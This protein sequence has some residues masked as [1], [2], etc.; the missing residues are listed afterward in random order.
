MINNENNENNENPAFLKEQIITYLGNKRAL[1][2]F[3][4][5]GF[6]FARQE[7]K[8]DKFSFCDAFS[9]SG[10]VSRFAKAYSSFIVANDLEDYSKLINSCYLSNKND[11]NIKDLETMHQSLCENLELKKGFISTLYAPKNDEYIQKNERVFYTQRNALYLDSMRSKIEKE[12]PKE[13]QHFFIAPLIYS[14]SVHSNTGGVF[15]GF[16]KDKFGVGKFGGQACNALSRIKGE[17]FLK[18]P[19]FSNFSCDFEVYKKEVQDLAKELDKIEV[20]Y[21]DPPYNQHPYG[22]N[23]FM[24]NLIANYQKPKEISRVSGIVQGW[25]KSAF[26]SPKFAQD[27]LF[28]LILNLKAKIIL[29]SYNCEGFVKKENFLKKLKSLGKCECIEKPYN[30]FRAS[31]NLKNRPIHIQE[32]LYMLVK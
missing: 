32:Q 17:I 19:I 28:E 12:I 11:L 22:S 30:T 13:F 6:D 25:N 8:K 24:L 7:L 2:G 16:Y 20:A 27:A 3:L 1:L 9:G 15:K 29:L 23:Y 31:R 10:I 18:M 21:L 5:Q 26:N 4:K 14:A